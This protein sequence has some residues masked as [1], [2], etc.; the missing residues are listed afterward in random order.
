MALY[1]V[2][3]E[4]PRAGDRFHVRPG[5]SLGRAKADINLRDPK[6]SNKHAY[7]KEAEGELVL[8]DQGST[9]GIKVDGKKVS[10]IKL[11]A[12]LSFV[13][14]ISHIEVVQAVD[15]EEELDLEEWRKSLLRTVAKGSGYAATGVASLKPFQKPVEL[16]FK[17]GA[18]THTRVFSYGP[19]Q[20]DPFSLD[21]D[22]DVPKSP[23]IFFEL[24]PEGE[25]S[26]RFRTPHPEFVRL[27]GE[28]KNAEMLK[29]G[30]VITVQDL[31]LKVSIK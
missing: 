30:D 19:R 12:G 11:T 10:E 20:I 8:V 29:D 31:E 26:I 1:L 6:V 21:I 28:A 2:I 27:N 13:V 24:I 23:E 3:K 16:Q 15:P 18:T 14:G 4:G 17:V 22:V 25:S 9:N 5:V 7:I